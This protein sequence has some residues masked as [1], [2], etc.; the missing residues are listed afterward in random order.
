[1]NPRVFLTIPTGMYT[2]SSHS[3]NHGTKFP[4]YSTEILNNIVE[5]PRFRRQLYA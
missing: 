4:A 2:Q 1:M 5:I 3:Q